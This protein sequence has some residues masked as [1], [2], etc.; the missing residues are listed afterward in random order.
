MTDLG[1]D[2]FFRIIQVTY[3]IFAIKRSKIDLSK[4]VLQRKN[5]GHRTCLRKF[6]NLQ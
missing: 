3:Q 4:N 5:L 2:I 6:F 1:S